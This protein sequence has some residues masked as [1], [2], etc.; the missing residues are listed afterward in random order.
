LDL[1]VTPGHRDP[2]DP[3]AAR[4]FKALLDQKVMPVLRVF[5]GHKVPR[6]LL[7]L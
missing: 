1:K 2:R 3:R 4:A 7:V 6:D 5:R